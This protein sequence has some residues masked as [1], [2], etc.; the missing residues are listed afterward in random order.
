M[1]DPLGLVGTVIDD[2]YQVESLVGEGGFAIVYKAT[3]I[4]FKRPVAIK[5]FR[6]LSDFGLESRD[7]LMSEFVQEGRLLAE[8]SERSA[9]IVQA[10]DIGTLIT[11]KGDWIPYMV[12]E[13]LEGASLE[14]VF[15]REN[16]SRL[17]PR[18]TAEAIDLLEPIAEALSL[19][20]KI[21]I[22]HR[23]VKPANMFII[24]DPRGDDAVVKLLDFGIAKVV[25][26]VQKLGGSIQKTS[27]VI[28]TFTPG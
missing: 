9:A 22:A 8:L 16:A 23:D 1:E 21:G 18:T 2:K 13:W 3:H 11:R 15:E 14:Q 12:L 6:A 28:T 25:Q 5:A 20:H 17:P 24:G 4:L 10:R 19:A 27:G 26:D 7:R